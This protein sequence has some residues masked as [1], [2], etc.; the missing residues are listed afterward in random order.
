M[1]NTFKMS[2]HRHPRF[3]LHARNQT[4]AAARHDDVDTVGHI[5]QHMADRRAIRGRHQLNASGWEFRRDESF[6]K[7]CM[8]CGAGPRAFRTTPPNDR[9]AGL[10]AYGAGVGGYTVPGSVNTAA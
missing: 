9:I 7:T 10:Q 1:A 5:G 3:A 4:L 8:N 6:L 2:D